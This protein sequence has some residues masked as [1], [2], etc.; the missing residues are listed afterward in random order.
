MV[1]WERAREERRW[2]ELTVAQL[3][4][5]CHLLGERLRGEPMPS[6]G[7][8]TQIHGSI[9]L[10]SIHL[11]KTIALDGLRVLDG[12]L[13]MAYGFSLYERYREAMM[14]ALTSCFLGVA[15]GM[16]HAFE[17]DHLTAVTTL[18]LD[19]KSP[20]RSAL[21]GAA[22]GLGHTLALLGLCGALLLMQWQ[23][24]PSDIVLLEG[25]VGVMLVAFGG[26]TLRRALREGASGPVRRHQHGPA[27]H[28]HPT[29]GAHLHLGSWILA[30][31]PLAVGFAHGLAGSGAL[32]ALVVAAMPTLVGRLLYIAMFGAGSA[33]GMALLSGVLGVPLARLASRPRLHRALSLGAGSFSVA[34]GLYWTAEVAGW[35]SP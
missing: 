9:P 3:G 4:A 29:S 23:L 21:L 1:R 22:W 10:S 27:S 15:L 14:T 16:R 25:L 7:P 5:S 17:P 34:F 26:W 20:W 33:L 13:R 8:A 31:R 35:L 18:S 11:G 28:A 12:M 30:R 24:R 6:A 2:C 32:T 19:A